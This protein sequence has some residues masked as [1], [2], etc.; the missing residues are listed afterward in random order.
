M[1][2]FLR[3]PIALNSKMLGIV[4]IIE[5]N[6]QIHTPNNKAIVSLKFRIRKNHTHSRDEEDNEKNKSTKFIHT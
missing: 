2:K 5:N 1:R 6:V 3:I 4:I